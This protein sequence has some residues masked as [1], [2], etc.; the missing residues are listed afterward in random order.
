MYSPLKRFNCGPGKNVGIVG[1]GGLGHF[2]I[3]F[4]KALGADEVVALSC[5]TSKKDDMLK[6]GATD[7]IST[8]DDFR[9]GHQARHYP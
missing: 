8:E 3:L 2:G 7:Y 6:L 1:A 5:G 4:A 9:L